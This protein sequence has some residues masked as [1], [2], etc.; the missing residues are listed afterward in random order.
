VSDGGD[1]KV[2]VYKCRVALSHGV[3]YLS[4][5]APPLKGIE[6]SDP[7][8]ELSRKDI[9]RAECRQ[10]RGRTFCIVVVAREDT[11]WRMRSL[12]SM[13]VEIDVLGRDI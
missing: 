7:C 12:P 3:A 8:R 1:L 11:R 10:G 13:M 4:Y 6:L 9:H 2:I 5:N